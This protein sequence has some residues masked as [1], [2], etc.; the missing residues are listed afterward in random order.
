MNL[1]RKP[2]KE[3]PVFHTILVPLYGSVFGEK[4]L[5]YALGVARKANAALRLVHV[6]PPRHVPDAS[7]N[8]VKYLKAHAERLAGAGRVRVS[9][10]VLEGPIDERLGEYAGTAPCDLIILTSHGRG[11][12]ARFWLGGVTD[13]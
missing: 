11:A 6:V 5:P 3:R 1:T 12:L 10:D 8:A 4:A 2:R 13:K 9:T 7:A